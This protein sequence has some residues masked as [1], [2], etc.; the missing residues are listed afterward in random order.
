MIANVYLTIAS[1]SIGIR[2]TGIDSIDLGRTGG[3]RPPKITLAI[4]GCGEDGSP[5]WACPCHSRRDASTT[6]FWYTK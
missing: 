6:Y 2:R 5:S 1:G 3:H 4:N